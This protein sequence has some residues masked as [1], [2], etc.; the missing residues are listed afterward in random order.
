MSVD[1]QGEVSEK[2]AD[3]RVIEGGDIRVIEGRDIKA[4]LN[5][6]GP[7]NQKRVRYRKDRENSWVNRI[8]AGSA[9]DYGR[10]KRGE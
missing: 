2:G 5:I 7:L 3:V 10:L 1:S 9:R 6:V 4:F 8:R